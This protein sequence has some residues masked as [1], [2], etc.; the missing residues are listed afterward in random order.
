MGALFFPNSLYYLFNAI[1]PS[2]EKVV[3]PA[4]IVSLVVALALVRF[5][6]NFSPPQLL[7]LAIYGLAVCLC[8]PTT[9]KHL[10]V[11]DPGNQD[12]LFK[13]PDDARHEGYARQIHNLLRDKG[14]AQKL[15]SFYGIQ[16]AETTGFA[17]GALALWMLSRHT[18]YTARPVVGFQNWTFRPVLYTLIGTQLLCLPANYGVM[19]L[20]KELPCVTVTLR[21]GPQPKQAFYLISDL[22][23]DRAQIVLLSY[24][25]PAG[26]VH[27]FFQPDEVGQVLVLQEC[28]NR[29]ILSWVTR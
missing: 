3:I 5:R 18:S 6:V 20:S 11:F 12:L 17:L 13:L 28:G 21:K 2:F 25:P 10:S 26:Y 7:V 24:Q 4:V 23:V 22:S 9:Q 27:H 14:G 16:L 19:C 8:L 1:L 15:R 29:N